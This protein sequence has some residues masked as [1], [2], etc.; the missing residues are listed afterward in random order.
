MLFSV[1]FICFAVLR[2]CLTN[3]YCVLKQ[4]VKYFVMAAMA[5]ATIAMKGCSKDDPAPEQVAIATVVGHTFGD[6]NDDAGTYPY[7]GMEL[8]VSM[9]ISV[10]STTS[11]SF[12]FVFDINIAG[13]PQNPATSNATC[14]LEGSN[15]KF[16][17]NGEIPFIWDASAKTI[18][19][20]EIVIGATDDSVN[21][22]PL[23]G[24]F[25]L[26]QES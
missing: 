18:T 6:T 8:P 23:G 9:T 22:V 14:T 16:I 20:E 15:C 17:S 12:I 13:T 25:V 10:T 3:K 5:V 21:T 1:F 19:I 26:E 7:Q 4:F 11:S 2:K 24:R